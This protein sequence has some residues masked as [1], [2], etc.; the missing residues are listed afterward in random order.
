[1]RPIRI[2]LASSEELRQDRDAFRLSIADLNDNWLHRGVRLQ[3]VAWESFVDAMS[4]TGL[5]DEYDRALAG[6]DLFVMLF[7]RKV[8]I[9]TR[10]EFETAVGQFQANGRPRIYTYFRTTPAPDAPQ[11]DPASVAGF[12]QRL[13]ALHH[14]KTEY[15]NVDFLNLHFQRQLERLG[16]EH[17]IDFD[18]AQTDA[19]GAAQVPD[20]APRVTAGHVARPVELAALKAAL[21][22]PGG[23]LAPVTVGLH[24]MGGVGKTTLARLL[25]ADPALRAA[26]PDGILWTAIGTS[27]GDVRARLASLVQALTGSDLGCSTQELARDALHKA[28]AGRRLLLVI[29]DIWDIAHVSELLDASTGCARVLTTRSPALLPAGSQ[30]MDVGGMSAPDAAALLALGLAGADA[31][32]VSALAGRLGRWPV[33]LRLANRRLCEE[34][35]TGLDADA[36]LDAATATLDRDGIHAFDVA[37]PAQARDQAVAATMKDSLALLTPDERRR[38]TELAI[39]P[40]DLPIPL[41]QVAGLWRLTCGLA[42]D[43]TRDLV[44]HRLHALSL[45]DYDGARGQVHL[46]DVL[47]RHLLAQLDAAADPGDDRAALHARLA[48]HWGDSPLQSRRYAWRWLAHHRAQAAIA[49]RGDQRHTRAEALLALVTSPDWQAAHQNALQDPPALRD[50]MRSALDAAVADDTPAGLP[51]LVRAADACVRF[52]RAH[53]QATPVFDAARSGALDVARRRADLLTLDPHWRQALMLTAVWLCPPGTPERQALFDELAA[54]AQATPTTAELAQWVRA[55]LS[56]GAPPAFAPPALPKRATPMLVEQ[57]L[58]RLGGAAVNTEL[59]QDSGIDPRV[60]DGPQPTRGLLPGRPATSPDD[61]GSPSDYLAQQDAPWLLDFALQDP[62]AGRS[63]L[64]RYLGVFADYGYAEYRQSSCWRLLAAW[65]RFPDVARAGWLRDVVVR[66]VETAVAGGSVQFEQAAPVAALAYA[67]AAGSASARKALHDEAGL[68]LNRAQLMSS[69]RLGGDT[70]GHHKRRL[71]AHAEA[72]GWLLGDTALADPLLSA[73]L[74][75]ATSGFA[76]YQM[77]ACLALAE[78][79]R[80]LHE[81][82]PPPPDARIEAALAHAQSAAHNVQDPTFCARSTA[83]MNTLRR[84]WWPGFDPA[85]RASQLRE[86][87]SGAAFTGLHLVGHAYAGRLPGSL[88]SPAQR[89]DDRYLGSLQQLYLR[90]WEDLARLNVDPM[91][92]RKP[93]DAVAIPDSGLPA[94]AAARI[95]A[96]VLARADGEPLPDHRLRLLRA[97][98]PAAIGHPSALDAVLSRV[99]LAQARGGATPQQA[100]ALRAALDERPAVVEPPADTDSLTRRPS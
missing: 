44:S 60:P 24:G 91:A 27:G 74:N 42:D 76:G 78:S 18:T 23:A 46:H 40:Q 55:D 87:A 19:A 14:Y 54:G 62:A 61:P 71:A 47:R 11:A 15:G 83:R 43:V 41:A 20:Q 57:L 3:V 89:L 10:R 73:A 35:S 65:V 93:G 99:I 13:H 64:E 28:L 22:G 16:A 88:A 96:E 48:A 52:D 56:G 6:C 92:A 98:V 68:L 82:D 94:V 2:F 86:G 79:V 95:A 90:P 81:G 4:K 67:A 85:A 36:A 59:L 26:C 29:D 33:L 1:M 63:A 25:C 9:Y 34:V 69:G 21:I 77:P 5:Q 58:L 66:I 32:R 49:A 51:L 38:Y 50:A 75:L 39:F 7:W 12:E 30:R 31:Q 45:L 100:A 97:L 37:G 84:H 72:L 53:E 80:M 70:W 8:G 17:F